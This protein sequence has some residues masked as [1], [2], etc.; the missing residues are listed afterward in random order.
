MTIIAQAMISKRIR[1]LECF[2]TADKISPFMAC[3]LKKVA[4]E[5]LACEG[6]SPGVTGELAGRFLSSNTCKKVRPVV[7]T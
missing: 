5:K 6:S 1:L 4:F 2:I 3:N 7:L